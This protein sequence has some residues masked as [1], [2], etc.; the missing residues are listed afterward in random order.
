MYW[1]L[2]FAGVALVWAVVLT[3]LGLRLWRRG[4]ALLAELSAAEAKLEAAQAPSG[5]AGRSPQ[6]KHA[7]NRA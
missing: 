6:A 7:N 3:L 1:F 5:A 4:Q 2:L